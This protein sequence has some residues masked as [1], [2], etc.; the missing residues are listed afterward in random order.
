MSQTPQIELW[1]SR[2]GAVPVSRD[3]RSS[4][5]IP[6]HRADFGLKEAPA[7][8]CILYASSC[9]LS[10]RDLVDHFGLL[11]KGKAAGAAP[12]DPDEAGDA[13]NDPGEGGGGGKLKL[14]PWKARTHRGLA[15]EPSRGRPIPLIDHCHRLMQL[16]VAADVA[17]VNAH[18]DRHGLRQSPLFAQ[19]I[20][21]LIEQS[22]AD[23]I[24]DER[25]LLERLANHLRQLGSTAQTELALGD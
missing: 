7:S 16:W 13:D 3:F 19:L 10:E 12:D 14:K 2:P 9:R 11:V 4:I 15:D 5:L 8:P 24:P 25:S 21:A 1:G 17:Q 23:A 22:R 20:Q 6:L 18:L